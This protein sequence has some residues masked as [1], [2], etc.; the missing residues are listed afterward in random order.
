LPLP[1]TRRKFLLTTAT[2]LPVSYLLAK[3]SPQTPSPTGQFTAIENRL[4]GRLGVGVLNTQTGKT[5]AHRATERF[6]MCSTFKFLLVSDLLSRVD[7]NAETLDRFIS[8]TTADLLEYAPITKAHVQEGGMTISA[9]CAAAIEYSDNTAA[10]LLLSVVGGPAQ[11]TQYARSLGDSVTRLDRNEPSLNSATAG[12]E[13]DTT[14]PSSML[15]DIKKLLVEENQLS[16]AS[17]RQLTE[18][19]IGNT[20]GSH[21]LRA[22]LPTTWQVADKTGS[23]KN[24]ATN[25][26]AICW[27]PNR[28]ALLITAYFVESTAS[29]E[30][31]SAALA[32][33]GR[34]VAAE[35]V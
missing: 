19:M 7:R 2:L 13:R 1:F 8:Y 18:W 3:P 30:D 34:I 4:G 10:N 6:P 27:P 22:G 31:R 11:L 25:D 16:A 14:S 23:G 33:V 17:R 20:T 24:G 21:S 28:A 9:L 12:D 15:A 29:P 5:I 35:F 32:E 26:I